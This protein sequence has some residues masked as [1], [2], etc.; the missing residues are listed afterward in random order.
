MS[1]ARPVDLADLACRYGMAP[2]AFAAAAAEAFVA[3]ER[4]GL[5]VSGA[6][7][8]ASLMSSLT[9][10]DDAVQRLAD[11]GA[12][13]DLLRVDARAVQVAVASLLRERKR[14]LSP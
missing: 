4:A 10:K 2:E 7:P 8:T 9:A 12:A 13:I 6:T 11:L 5:L 1:D 3:A 14:L